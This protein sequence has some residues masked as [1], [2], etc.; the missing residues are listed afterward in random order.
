MSA[1]FQQNVFWFEIT[2]D[3]PGFVEDGQG[4]EQLAGED[5]DER[6]GQAAEGVL[7][8]ELVEVDGE[9]LKDEAQVSVVDELVLEAEQV[10]FVRGIPG[11]VE[12]IED[13]DFHHGLV[14]VSGLVLDDLD[15]DDFVGLHVL[16]LYDLSESALAEQI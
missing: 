3:Q 4:V 5:S 12:E 13:G 9:K 15:S 11:V 10:V 1:P 6:G 7:F 16:T 14:V 2:V 8:D